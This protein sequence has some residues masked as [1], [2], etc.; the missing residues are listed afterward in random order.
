MI[1]AAALLV[2]SLLAFPAHGAGYE[3]GLLRADIAGPEPIV[4]QASVIDG[5]TIEIHGVRIRLE[6]IDAP[7]SRQTCKSKGGDEVFRCGQ[8]A[9]FYLADM[10]GEHTVSCTESGKD[11]Y[12]RTLAHC[13]VQGQ[14]VSAAMVKAGWALAFVRYSKEYVTQEDEARADGAG[15]WA[16]DFVPPWDWRRGAR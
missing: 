4:G 12:K 11:R 3:K 2:L 14:D 13:S 6:G 7:E 16:T 1:R 5:D 8:R 9:A 10:L 15:M